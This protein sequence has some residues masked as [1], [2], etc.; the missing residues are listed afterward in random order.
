MNFIATLNKE[1]NTDYILFALDSKEKTLRKDLD[2]NYK[3]NRPVP[4]EDLVKQLPVAIKWIKE[5][6]FKKMM[7]PGYEADDIIGSLVTYAKKNN[8]KVRVVS[9]DKDLYQLIDDDIVTMHDPMKKLDINEEKC[10][11]KY[12]VPPKKIVE[13]LAIVGDAADNIPGVK[14]IGPKGAI[15]LLQEFPSL[16]AIY[17]NLDKIANPRTV[18]LLTESKENAF[19]SKT[20]ATLYDDLIDTCQLEEFTFPT[21][22]PILKIADDLIQY[23]MKAILKRAGAAY[24]NNA[25]TVEAVAVK[26]FQPLLLNTREKLNKVLDKIKEDT[27]V[28][29]DTETTGIDVQE[30][31]IVGFSFAFDEQKAYY[32]PIAHNY[33]GV[34]EQVSMEDAKEAL[35]RLLK[36]KIVGQNLKYDYA[37]LKHNFE[38]VDLPVYADTMIMSWLLDSSLAASLD[39]MAMR[40]FQHTMIPFKDTVKKGETFAS[41]ELFDACKY[42]AEDAWMTL[43]LYHFFQDKLGVALEK[44][45]TDVEYPFINTLITIEDA[46]IKVDVSFFET[47]LQEASEKIANLTKEIYTQ[48]GT[49]FNI[50]ST[51]QL[52]AVL[53]ETLSLKAGK[54]TKTGYS[55][56][57]KVLHDLYDDHAIIPKLLEYREIHKLRST[58][59]DP[60]LKLGKKAKDARIHTSFLQTG[61]TTG[62]LSSKNPNLQNIPVRT[63]VGRRIREGFIAKEGYKLIGIDYSQIE[64]RLLAHF[65]Q[66]SALLNAF[67]EKKDIHLETAIKIF[68][69]ESAKEK[70]N[71]AKSINFGLLYGMGSRKL[72]Q[73]IDVTTAEAK[74]YIENYFASFPTVKNYLASIQESAKKENCVH[75]LLGRR[76]VFDYEN[77]NAFEKA[78]YERESVNTV[79]QGS[80]ADL[81]KLSMNKLLKVMNPEDGAMLLQIHDELIFEVK[82]E[83]AESYAAQVKEVMENIYPLSVPLEC[84]VSIGKNWGQLK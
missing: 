32:V 67:L 36:Y 7:M 83:K 15:K 69:Q 27:I 14:G 84:S 78:S 19:L 73:T 55:T 22:N 65:S 40:Y 31:K 8:L 77:A 44:V 48:A 41:V 51:Q 11:E 59:I 70:R 66:D 38:M 62:R 4:P 53:F 58:Y 81:I 75:T 12:G 63:E 24:E 29:F 72:A 6:G 17:E 18:K 16:E 76:R 42:A 25:K 60:L 64:L 30:A 45:A 13:Y 33:L 47:L 50:N 79:F 9:H 82:E 80:A 71:V 21:E 10:I 2:P 34:G 56:N 49:E 35:E 43:K 3:A 46:G 28:A 68:G 54:K 26:K 37:I 61:T 1:H 23:D 52:G 5:M 39:K 20:L 57:E 74:Q